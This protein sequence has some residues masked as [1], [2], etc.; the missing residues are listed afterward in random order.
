VICLDAG[1]GGSDPGAVANGLKESVVA[2]EVVNFLKKRLERAGVEV[3]LSRPN[4]ENNPGIN[5]RWQFANG[6]RAD[7]FLS[8][9]V[10]AGGGTGAETF[11]YRASTDR[12]RRSEA[13]SRAVN[14]NYAHKMGLRNRGVKPDTQTHIGNWRYG[15]RRCPPH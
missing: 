5:E 2:F 1:H 7:Y 9:H 11:F 12:S 14:D 13:F 8:I 10:N 15:I 3:V 4:A 6:S